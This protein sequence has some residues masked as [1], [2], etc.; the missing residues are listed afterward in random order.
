MPNNYLS[1]LY[2]HIIQVEI[3]NV[4]L[5]LCVCVCVGGGAMVCLCY[6]IAFYATDIYIYI[7]QA[8]KIRRSDG[9][10]QPIFPSGKRKRLVRRT[11]MRF[12]PN[13]SIYLKANGAHSNPKSATVIVL[14]GMTCMMFIYHV[15]W[16]KTRLKHVSTKNNIKNQFEPCL[17][18]GT[19]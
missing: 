14:A 1:L 19:L 16:S 4:G 17:N 15:Y 8:S 18:K 3:K 10:G 9:S 11:T 12:C 7:Y 5:K 2:K 6:N 13:D